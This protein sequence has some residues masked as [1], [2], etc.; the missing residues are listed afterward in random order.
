MEEK[1][2]IKE[3]N[4]MVETIAKLTCPHCNASYEVDM[5]TN[6]YH[7]MFL[8]RNCGEELLKK[9]APVMPFVLVQT[10]SAP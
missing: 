1:K 7:I 4:N 2:V 6:Y 3:G 9:K 10:K 8:C 5:P